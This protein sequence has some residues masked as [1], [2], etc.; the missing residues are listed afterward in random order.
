LAALAN[1]PYPTL[2]ASFRRKSKKPSFEFV[3]K[4][5]NALK[6]T[7]F[8]LV[9]EEFWDTKF[10]DDAS[11]ENMV[12]STEGFVKYIR[13]LGY[14]VSIRKV[15]TLI[16]NDARV[17][18]HGHTIVEISKNSNTFELKKHEFEMLQ[19]RTKESIRFYFW[20][21]EHQE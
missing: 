17:L 13:S 15:D 16:D 2:A 11:H 12:N 18:E 4:I 20:E 9:G 8:E 14:L 10:P 21:K 7:P 1:I 6:T 3:A 5:A 19:Q